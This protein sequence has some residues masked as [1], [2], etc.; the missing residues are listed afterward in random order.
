MSTCK[1]NNP[2]FDYVMA[3]NAPCE[4]GGCNK[5]FG[6]FNWSDMCNSGENNKEWTCCAKMKPGL[7]SPPTAAPNK[8][9]G[10]PPAPTEIPN[11]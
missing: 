3:L 11:I 4:L 8:A 10:P 9:T 2:G 7:A 1:K 6:E 5:K